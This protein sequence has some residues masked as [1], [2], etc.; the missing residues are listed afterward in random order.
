MV[1]TEPSTASSAKTGC[2][3][4]ILNL[5]NF[6]SQFPFLRIFNGVRPQATDSTAR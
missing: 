4:R 6:I 2:G 5:D 3:L 1:P